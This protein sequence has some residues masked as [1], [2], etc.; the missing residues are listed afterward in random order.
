[1]MPY[2]GPSTPSNPTARVPH[3]VM[4]VDESIRADFLELT[5]GSL[6]TPELARLRAN[7][8]DYG[9]SASGGNCSHYSNALLRFGAS[10]RDTIKTV[11]TNP[12]LWEY[13]KKAG[14]R[15][16]FIDAQAGVNQE[17]RIAP[18]FHEHA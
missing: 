10:R 15:T 5:P 12:T 2:E 13:A 11:R 17:S 16:V 6:H 1:M 4:L 3:I 18:K 9:P 8:I 14:Y 7:F